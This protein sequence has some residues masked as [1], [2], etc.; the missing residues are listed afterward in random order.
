MEAFENIFSSAIA[1]VAQCLLKLNPYGY[2]EQMGRAGGNV[3]HTALCVCDDIHLTRGNLRVI[4]Q[5]IIS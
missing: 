3:E 5:G 4:N 2:T 1:K